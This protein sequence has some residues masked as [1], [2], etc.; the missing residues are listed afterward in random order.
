MK[1]STG[2]SVRYLD[3][4]SASPTTPCSRPEEVHASDEQAGGV[5]DHRL[6]SGCGKWA[7]LD[8]GGSGEDG[9]QGRIEA[10]E[11]SQDAAGR[12]A[13]SAAARVWTTS[14]VHTPPEHGRRGQGQGRRRAI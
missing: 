3:T 5:Q 4:P 2:S 10:H 14:V 13:P 12:T 11:Q 6:R 1:T 7:G 8:G 9:R